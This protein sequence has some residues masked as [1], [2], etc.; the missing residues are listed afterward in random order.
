MLKAVTFQ[1]VLAWILASI[2]Y[3]VGSRIEKGIINWTNVIVI[4]IVIIIAIVIINSMRKKKTN[5]CAGCPYCN[6]CKKV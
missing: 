4:G 2:V 5:E 1:T 6:A 3:Q